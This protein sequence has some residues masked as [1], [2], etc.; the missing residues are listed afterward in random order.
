M[1]VRGLG[2]LPRKLHE[3]D[4]LLAGRGLH[5]KEHGGEVVQRD[6]LGA[7]DHRGRK[8]VIA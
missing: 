8:F 4:G 3:L 5:A 2:R 1:A 7:I 6:P